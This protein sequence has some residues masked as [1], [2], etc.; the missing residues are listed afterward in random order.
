MQR[1]A[2]IAAAAASAAALAAVPA[3]AEGPLR[4]GF[5]ALPGSHPGTDNVV[6]LIYSA[7]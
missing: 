3:R 5:I 6:S 4:V 7:G 2:L 1:A